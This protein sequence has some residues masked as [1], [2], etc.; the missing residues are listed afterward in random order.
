M[1]IFTPVPESFD[2]QTD[3]ELAALAAEIQS[4]LANVAAS[5]ADFV[6]D[7]FSGD[8]LLAAAT[9]AR[10]G[11]TRIRA[12]LAA[13]EEPEPDAETETADEAET[14]DSELAASLEALAADDEPA[15]A[16]VPDLEPAVA[17]EL[18]EEA[19]VVAAAPLPPVAPPAPAR[20][21]GAAPVANAIPR[22]S[23][24]AA[25]GIVPG[26]DIGDEL[27]GLDLAEAMLK[28]HGLFG[29]PSGE[30]H[31][32]AKASWKGMYP[33]ERRLGGNV[34]ENQALI[35]S[36]TDHDRIKEEL[37][38]RRKNALTASGGWCA[39]VVPYYDLPVFGSTARPV[40][41]AL[42]GFDASRGGISHARPAS[43]ASIN[44]A[45]GIVTAAEDE[46]GGTFG[47][48][49][50]QVPDCPDFV[51]VQTNAVYHCLQWGNMVSR[52]YPELVSQWSDLTMTALARLAETYLLTR[53]D[54]LSTAVT[55][56]GINLGATATLL[57]QVLVAG[58]AM[59]NRHRMDAD[60]VLRA[61]F[62]EWVVPL[63]V[64]DVIRSQFQRFDT[65]EAKITALL[66]QFN[67]EPTFYKDGATGAAQIFGAQS[68]GALLTF[69]SH[70]RWYLYPEGSFIYL[71]SGTLEI[72][73]VRD[74]ILNAS[75]DF[76]IFGEFFENVAFVG[77]E[78]LAIDSLVCD[79]GQVAAPSD[80]T[81]PISYA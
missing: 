31:P 13:R 47:A 42:P 70:V 71:D 81:C 79:S 69:P 74:S 77:V 76:Q 1:H 21:T 24:T 68:A 8:D 41:D 35:A 30:R 28:R 66:R 11:L 60:T 54:S 67:I 26:I 56:D 43:L 33:T 61:M 52:A 10:E 51:D 7:E 4:Q 59:R 39:P 25:S 63:M 40:R 46:A 16:V 64:S 37:R 80:V 22:V 62:P 53:I 32:L 73:L 6:S 57:P 27:G 29:G 65:D 17:E 23:L 5:P 12:E 2:G 18:V 75:N 36:A 48:K 45:V 9:D 14:V 58:V 3:A 72:G 34:M 38:R 49:S 55:A 20:S 50:C 44:D 78:A 15:A 19:A